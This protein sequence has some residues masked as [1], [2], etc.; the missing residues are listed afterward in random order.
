MRT[1]K[2]AH[3]RCQ[4]PSHTTLVMQYPFM[5]CLC[6]VISA[7]TF[8]NLLYKHRHMFL[9]IKL[10]QGHGKMQEE[11][12]AVFKELSLRVEWFAIWI[13]ECHCR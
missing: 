5:A 13:L 8:L 11:I 7:S 3:G 6:R 12:A 2:Y 4:G 9:N 1:L 10:G